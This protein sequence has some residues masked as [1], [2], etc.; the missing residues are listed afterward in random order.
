MTNLRRTPESFF[1]FYLF[2][3]VLMLTMSMLF[4]SIGAL[5]RTLAG[6]MAPASVL[7]L[8]L[9]IYTGFTVPIRD[10]HPWFRWLNYID[11]VA[12]AFESLMINE[13]DGREFPCSN[14]VP[15]YAEVAPDQRVCSVVGAETSSDMVSGSSFISLSFNYTRSH[16]W[17]NLGILIAMGF[18]FCGIYLSATEYISARRSKGEVLV[19]RRGLVPEEK[20]KEDEEGAPIDRPTTKDLVPQR[21]I[22]AGDVPPSIQKQTAIFH[23]EAV[24]YDIKIKSETRRLLDDVDGWVKPGTLTA[25][26]YSTLW[27]YLYC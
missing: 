20:K 5:S 3:F 23:W 18:F 25:V 10:M 26:S 27:Y 9:V 7:I 6:A 11:P 15:E 12:Y 22:S 13:F 19:F 1:T 14:Y 16:K 21:T 2:S 8:A 4:R 17:R 24:N